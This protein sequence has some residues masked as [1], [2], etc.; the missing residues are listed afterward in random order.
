MV[1]PAITHAQVKHDYNWALGHDSNL[2]DSTFGGTDINFNE[3]PI[4]LSY[5][6][7]DMNIE[8]TNATMSDA[9]GNLIF[10]TNGCKIFNADHELM[11]NGDDINPGEVHDDQCD[12]AYPIKQGIL[13][14]PKPN[15]DSVYYLFH[16]KAIFLTDPFD[17]QVNKLLFTK[18][19]MT[20]NGGKGAVSFKNEPLINDILAF[21]NLTAAKHSNGNHWWLLAPGD[22]SKLYYSIQITSDTITEPSIQSIGLPVSYSGGG[23]GQACFS[24]DG[25]KY[26]RYNKTDQVFLFDFNRSTGQLSNFQQLIVADTAYIGGAAF[27]PN[28]RYLYISSTL[29]VYQF[30]TWAADIQASKVVVATYD[31]FENPF[32]TY[33]Q[34]MQMGPDCRI[35]IN[36]GSSHRSFHVINQPDEPG[37]ACDLQQHSLHLPTDNF[38]AMP[39]FPNYR[40]GTT[41]TYPCDP[42]ID[43]PVSTKE[44]ALT[45]ANFN[46]Y[47]NPASNLV[48][49]SYS[50]ILS[51]N[52]KWVLY[53]YVGQAVKQVTLEKGSNS[54]EVNLAG[55]PKGLYF[56]SVTVAGE[57]LESGKLVVAE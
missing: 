30:D 47:P 20:L 35:Y 27:S 49:I 55:L 1:F 21:G 6:F 19:D 26:A 24:P 25:T 32:P 11:E 28:S 53:T 50:D 13:S 18:L 8:Q 14:L 40:L 56:Y 48:T 33:F 37:L 5:V 38:A 36:S 42:T 12:D 44:Q 3:S 41:P 43:L 15:E 23:S 57:V 31:G 54:T 52:V 39:H 10:Y 51:A 45:R 46:V 7:R 9:D 16:Q 29:F 22:T 4:S 2:I 17:V 34:L